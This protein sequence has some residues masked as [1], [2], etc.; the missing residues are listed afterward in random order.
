MAK[1]ILDDLYWC[2]NTARA[3]DCPLI[4]VS[5]SEIF[6]YRNVKTNLSEDDDKVFHNEY[7]VR[8]EYSSAKLL[9]EI[10][11]TNIGKID[12]KLKYQIIRP[13]NVTGHINYRMVVLFYRGLLF[14]QLIANPICLW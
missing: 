4:F 11:L 12:K 10:V 3:S 8:N 13:F 1:M 7:T 14:K 2:I 9:A 5:T 6:G